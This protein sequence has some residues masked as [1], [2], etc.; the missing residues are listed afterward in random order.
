MKFPIFIAKR[1]LISKRKHNVVNIISGISA[2]G[3][4]I[5]AFAL[6]C[7]LSVF[8]GFR[9]LIDGLFT[10][11]DPQIKVVNAN[12]KFFKDDSAMIARL[13]QLESICGVSRTIQ[14]QALISYN[15]KQEVIT[16]KGVD[17]RYPGQTGILDIL[18]GP[19]SYM[20]SD[21]ISDYIIPGIG[22]AHKL[23]SGAV[24]DK[25]YMVYVP[26]PGAKYSATNPTGALNSRAFYSPGVLFAVKQ[27]PYD[28]CYALVSLEAAQEL[29]GRHNQISA[30]EIK[31]EPDAPVK[32][33]VKEIAGIVGDGFKV[34]DRYQQ[35]YQVFKVVNIEKL[36]SYL[37]IVLILIIALFNIISSVIMLMIEK[38]ED[39]Q[40]LLKMGAQKRQISNIFVYNSLS[41]SSIGSVCGIIL[42]II[43]VLLQQY[44]GFIRLGNQ[45]GF[46]VEAYPVQLRI[47]DI[48]VVLLSVFVVSLLSSVILKRTIY[49]NLF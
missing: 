3:I 9:S 43:A 5:A 8:N 47:T 32:K 45:G 49:R 21:D 31:L 17:S 41:I 18:T 12:G 28:D 26:K 24:T 36:V 37:F 19:G 44:Y 20:L 2:C 16:L 35:Q 42:G 11:F 46:I 22:L 33:S 38:K 4:G 6:M 39:I 30:L 7:T 25:P 48:A 13:E 40:I 1:Y 15:S 27:N 34:M 10:K 23:E 29:L 14:D